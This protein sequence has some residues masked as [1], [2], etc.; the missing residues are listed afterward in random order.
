[1]QQDLVLVSALGL[2][3]VERNGHHFIDGFAGRP[4]AEA[5]AYRAAHPDLYED[6]PHGPRLRIREGLLDIGSLATPGMGSAV[7]PDV[8]AMQ[9][10]EKA[11][12][13]Q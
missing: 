13:P 4:A 1:V 6:T 7:W 8:S 9:L 10:M 5:R 12:W 3:H 2:A 11:A